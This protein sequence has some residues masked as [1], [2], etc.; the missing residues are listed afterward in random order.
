MHSNGLCA[1]IITKLKNMKGKIEM[2]L[3]KLGLKNKLIKNQKENVAYSSESSLKEVIPTKDNNKSVF[4]INKINTT[5]EFLI[6]MKNSKLI[7]EL[8]RLM[9]NQIRIYN[10][11]ET[12][13]VLEIT[14]EQLEIFTRN[15]IKMEIFQKEPFFIDS[16]LVYEKKSIEYK[17]FGSESELDR[18]ILEYNK[19]LDEDKGLYFLTSNVKGYLGK[20]LYVCNKGDEVS[21]YLFNNLIGDRLNLIAKNSNGY[22]YFLEGKYSGLIKRCILGKLEG[23]YILVDSLNEQPIKNKEELYLYGEIN[24]DESIGLTKD[25]QFNLKLQE[26]FPDL[27]LSSVDYEIIENAMG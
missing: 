20:G 15:N 11:Y 24:N 19:K 2:R 10:E 16:I 23:T 6:N 22:I 26:S 7:Y 21:D 25:E 4:D 9:E 1:T 14:S 27:K 18:F 3:D 13:K 17:L 5:I 8:Y 12:H